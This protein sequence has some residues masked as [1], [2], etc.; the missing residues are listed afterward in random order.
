[1]DPTERRKQRELKRVAA[2]R[3]AET[4]LSPADRSEQDARV[5]ELLAKNEDAMLSVVAKINQTYEQKL[6]KPAPFMTFVFVGMQSTGKSTIMERF[7]GAPLNII[8]EGTGTRCP[9]DTTCI[10]DASCNEP[11]CTLYGDELGDSEGGENLS[12]GQ[13]FADIVA[14]NKRLGQEDRFSTVPLRLHYRAKSVQNM[15]FVDTPGIIENLSTGRDNRAQIKSILVSEM[16]KENTKLCVLVEPKD[17]G[18]NTII[19][20]CDETFGPSRDWTRN[21]IFLMTKFDKQLEDSRSG[22]KANKFFAEY[23]VNGCCPYL[24]I[25]PTL[26]KEDLGADALFD[27]RRKLLESADRIESERF[28]IW[29]REL[30]AFRNTNDDE[31]LDTRLA[32]KLGFP[33]AKKKMRAI[34]LEDTIKRLP[35]VTASLRS[36]LAACRDELAVLQERQRLTDPRELKLIVTDMLHSIE[37]RLIAYLDGDLSSALHY[38]EYLQTLWD[39]VSVED[40]SDW[41]SKPLNFYTEKE[42]D[43]RDLM[44]DSKDLPA[45]LMTEARFLGGKQVQRAIS[46]FKYTA[47]GCLPDPDELKDLVANTTGYMGGGLKQE[48]WEHALVEITRVLMHR[49]S[50]PGVNYIVKHIGSILRRLFNLAM[51]DVKQGKEKSATYKLV[52]PAVEAHLSSEFDTMLWDIMKT[53]AERTHYSVEPLYTTVNPGLPNFMPASGLDQMRSYRLDAD[54]EYVLVPSQKDTVEESWKEGF[55]RRIAALMSGARQAKEFLKNEFQTKVQTKK[56]FLPSDRSSMIA[57]EEVDTI[58]RVSFEYLVALQELVLLHVEFQVN[59]YLYEGFKTEVHQSMMQIGGNADWATLVQPDLS[60]SERISELED[61][62][63]SLT[64]SLREVEKLSL[65]L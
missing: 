29:K 65:K 54:G 1:M 39:E 14:H 10:H 55:G 5:V 6:H 15:R 26:P 24:T 25:T 53:A 60:V 59:H 49:V 52:P 4:P 11:V 47:L 61:Q 18:T 21:S 45:E 7:L 36:E 8:Q 34:M 44:A 22:S 38:P 30:D 16:S 64:E 48:N 50:Q 32:D 12:V 58:L 20:I 57:N 17:Y 56:T 41:A 51:L 46:V 62:M 40:A 19:R 37:A 9:L 33:L 35:E 28:D 43:W 23:F 13:V 42:D 31:D 63:T 3:Q 2:A 27:A